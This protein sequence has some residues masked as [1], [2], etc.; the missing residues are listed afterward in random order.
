M[1]SRNPNAVANNR[2]HVKYSFTMIDG[3]VVESSQSIDGYAPTKDAWYEADGGMISEQEM[4]NRTS[5]YQID[6]WGWKEEQLEKLTRP[7]GWDD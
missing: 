6:G 5:P 4:E 3:K 2:M 1:R 7:E